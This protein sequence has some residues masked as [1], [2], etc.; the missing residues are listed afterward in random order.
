M[1][2]KINDANLTS[3]KR[4]LIFLLT[5]FFLI[6]CLLF[7]SAYQSGTKTA[8]ALEDEGNYLL[9]TDTSSYSPVEIPD[10]FFENYVLGEI[11]PSPDVPDGFE[12]IG[13]LYNDEY[14]TTVEVIDGDV[15]LIPD[16]I[17][18]EP[19]VSI[20][21]EFNRTDRTQTLTAEVSEYNNINYSYQWYIEEDGAW[22][23]IKGETSKIL[24][25]KQ[26][27]NSIKSGKYKCEVT[28]QAGPLS[29]TG[30]DT[31]SLDMNM[32]PFGQ[33]LPIIGIIALVI[34]G[35]IIF[36]VMRKRRK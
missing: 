26:S 34:I 36:F 21:M 30:Y 9:K 31:E 19:M 12:F 11:L 17:L 27:G 23:I 2:T 4:Q 15:K 7:V 29:A 13:W 24:E 6:M 33:I 3:G 20:K 1:R 35:L 16:W 22:T 10:D 14:I 18:L 28:V 25:I 8:F 32:P 5:S